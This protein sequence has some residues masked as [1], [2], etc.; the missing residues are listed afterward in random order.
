MDPGPPQGA[1]REDW[2]NAVR[3]TGSFDVPRPQDPLGL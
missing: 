2:A 1:Q 3:P